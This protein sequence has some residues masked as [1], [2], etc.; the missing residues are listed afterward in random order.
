MYPV[1]IPTL[2]VV[3]KRSTGSVSMDVIVFVIASPTSAYV[4][5]GMMPS[6]FHASS[7]VFGANFSTS[8][9]GSSVPF[10]NSEITASASAMASSSVDFVV[11]SPSAPANAS[12]G[13]VGYPAGTVAAELAA[14]AL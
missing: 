13:F 10:F 3:S 12:F 8:I 4:P 6:F 11:S 9:S 1:A 2:S 7:L 5:P 14:D